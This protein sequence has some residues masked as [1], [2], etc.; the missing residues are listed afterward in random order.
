MATVTKMPTLTDQ[1]ISA[2]VRALYNGRT[3]DGK[4]MTADDVADA[5]GV[6]HG[7]ISNRLREGGW[8]AVEVKALADYFNVAVTDL[9]S[10]MGGMFPGPIGDGNSVLPRRDS[11]TQP[12]GC[13]DRWLELVA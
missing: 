10:G 13:V 3:I 9:Y 11:N 2:T 5:I 6:S 4:R 7:T 12:A 1:V 8:K